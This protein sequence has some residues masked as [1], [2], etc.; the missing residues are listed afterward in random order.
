MNDSI[1]LEFLQ[2]LDLYRYE[3]PYYLVS[4]E[5]VDVPDE[6]RSNIVTEQI[7]GIPLYDSR[8][9]HSLTKRG[10]KIVQHASDIFHDGSQESTNA[11]CRESAE[12]VSKELH[13]TRVICYDYRVS[14]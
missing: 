13:A 9:H 8:E 10:F 14:A 6:E 12:L 7:S 5:G 2:E 1:T 11:Y 4:G 3:K